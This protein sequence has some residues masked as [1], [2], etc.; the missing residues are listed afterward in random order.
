MSRQSTPRAAARPGAIRRELADFSADARLL[1]IS[2]L[3]LA[4]GAASA[5]VAKALVAL[6]Q[7]ITNLAYHHAFTLRE[8]SPAGSELGPWAAL[9]PAAGGLAIGL[10]ARYGSEK[11]RGH[12]IPEAL[13]AIL[14]GES[15]M[16]PRVAVLKPVSSALSIGTGGPFGAE[17]PIIM[18]GGAVGSLVAQLFRLSAAERKTLLV[19]G[20]ATQLWRIEPSE[21][22]GAVRFRSDTGSLCLTRD[23]TA[24]SDALATPCTTFFSFLPLV[25]R[26][27]SVQAGTAAQEGA[28]GGG[29][30]LDSAHVTGV[31]G[32]QRPERPV[33]Q[34]PLPRQRLD[35]GAEGGEVG[36]GLVGT[37]RLRPHLGQIPSVRA[38]A[39]RRGKHGGRGNLDGAQAAQANAAD[40]HD[41]RQPVPPAAPAG[42]S[43][44]RVRACH[45]SSVVS[46]RG[47]G[48]PNSSCV[49]Q[50]LA[51]HPWH[52]SSSE[53]MQRTQ[54]HGRP[55]LFSGAGSG[56]VPS[57]SGHGSRSHASG[58]WGSGREARP[59][60]SLPMWPAHVVSRA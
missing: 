55:R 59:R 33:R 9:V 1:A 58:S 29:A 53:Q 2:A 37:L 5:L 46:E 21:Y 41:A 36:L 44:I 12:G 16:S 50:S 6:I 49:S 14:I 3:A 10:M 8:G 38:G 34:L 17:G 19:A 15:R 57:Q 52:R 26:A 32:V 56:V 42:P 39:V 40:G 18:T 60:M 51:P 24:G 22:P 7:L 13:E 11:I 4:I 23:G 28:E 45:R 35:G 31:L 30:R 20:A 54:P 25:V 48:R 47:E 27:S 43:D